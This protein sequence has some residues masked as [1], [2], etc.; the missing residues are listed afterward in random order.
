MNVKGEQTK[1]TLDQFEGPYSSENSLVQ[2]YAISNFDAQYKA[3]SQELAGIVSK[4]LQRD[5]VK[6]LDT[7]IRDQFRLASGITYGSD[8][9]NVA[10]FTNSGAIIANTRGYDGNAVAFQDLSG[11]VTSFTNSSRIVAGY[12]DDDT[13]DTVTSGLGQAIALDLSHSAAGVTRRSETNAQMQS[14][15]TISSAA[16]PMPNETQLSVLRK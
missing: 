15:A 7:D 12:T 1:I 2:P 10:A 9:A 3:N 8:A 14:P 5:V 11:S 6:L 4:H 16:A 13:T